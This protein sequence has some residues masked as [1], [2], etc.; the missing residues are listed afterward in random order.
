[1]DYVTNLNTDLED[2]LNRLE[3]KVKAQARV[4]E[5]QQG[6][7][8]YA[9]DSIDDLECDLKEAQGLMKTQ[10]AKIKEAQ[11]MSITTDGKM[12]NWI[13]HNPY[14]GLEERFEGLEAN[15]RMD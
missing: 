3:V 2:Q 4:I 15:F 6:Q 9:Q 12:R 8:T 14:H 11:E 5:E 7:L 13:N 1:V 10:E